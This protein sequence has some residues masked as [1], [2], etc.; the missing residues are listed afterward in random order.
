MVAQLVGY[1]INVIVVLIISL[2]I[3][4][5]RKR[6]GKAKKIVPKPPPI[7]YRR[8]MRI[9]TQDQ[10]SSLSGSAQNEHSQVRPYIFLGFEIIRETLIEILILRLVLR[11]LNMPFLT[12]NLN[13]DTL[14]W[15]LRRTWIRLE[16]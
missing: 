1:L 3:L 10:S 12:F 9:P 6:T 14:D 13:E 11:V 2:V 8:P 4:L 7:S 16:G 5:F 15:R